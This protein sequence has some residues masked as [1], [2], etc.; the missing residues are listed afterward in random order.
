MHKRSVRNPSLDLQGDT[1]TLSR[2]SRNGPG[3]EDSKE[4]KAAL[5]RRD[6]LKKTAFGAG[7]LAVGGMATACGSDP[8]APAKAPAAPAALAATA[9][10]SVRVDLTWLGKSSDEKGFR[11]ERSTTSATADFSDLAHVGT[12]VTNY[13]DK[14]VAPEKTYWYRVCATNAAGDSQ[15]TAVVSA[16]T[17]AVPVQQAAVP[18]KA[19][20]KFAIMG[21]T[22]WVSSGTPSVGDDGKNPNSCAVAIITQ[23]NQQFI[24]HGV[25]FVVHAGDLADSASSTTDN[26]RKKADGSSYI[27][28][29]AVAEDTRALFAQPLYAAG[30]GFFPLRGNHD[31]ATASAA[32]FQ[33]IYPQTQNGQ[34]N[35]TPA[36]VFELV[37]P[38]ADLQPSPAKS[39]NAFGLGSNFSSPAPNLNGLSYAFDHENVRFVLLD[40]FPASDSKNA[41][42][43][44]YAAGTAI[45]AQQSW[46][47]ATLAAKPAGGHA[48]VFAHKGLLTQDHT[49]VL[50]GN[51]AS[52]A[53]S[54]GLDPFIKSLAQ[55]G[56]RFFVCGHDHMHDRSQVATMDGTAR[57]TQ[58]VTA[59]DS[60]KFYYPA[61]LSNDA[62]YCGGARQTLLAHERNTVGYYIVT[63]DGGNI[64]L[65]FYSAPSYPSPVNGGTIPTT[66]TLNFSKRERFGY[67][68]AGKAF[69]VAQGASFTVVQDVSPGGTSAQILGGS[70]GNTALDPAGRLYS[71]A[72]STGWLTADGTASDI[73]LL[74]GIG[75]ML[76]SNQTDPFAVALGYKDGS[77][78]ADQITAGKLVLASPDESGTWANAVTLNFGGKTRFAEGPWKAS[79]PV[80]TYG[81]D[82]TNQ[83]VWAV[84]NHDVGSFAAVVSA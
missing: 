25:K 48:F 3:A 69:V 62:K 14:G 40:Q 39:G 76:G 55:N 53:S 11:I 21:D 18:S 46:I 83:T 68:L 32:E 37:N 1:M 79:Y 63:V 13:A 27:F 43:A 57:V 9:P 66:P 19:A 28:A 73:L 54:P 58:L 61:V 44:A 42:G 22:Q 78:T 33:R 50:F 16:T 81:V 36:E 74:T 10:S 70:N 77:A 49:D 26:T 75:Y 12:G 6:F 67:G 17:P 52:A 80:G 84:V 47:D 34:H 23:L 20:W 71:A 29:S 15:Y 24:D 51:D 5:N 38:D 30:I 2:K 59:S 7:S 64:T 45:P 60:N 56:V 35:S 4:Q 31:S 65:D 41:D 82:T 72:V 8:A